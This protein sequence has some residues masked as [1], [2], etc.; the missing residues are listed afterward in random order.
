ME[1]D[2]FTVNLRIADTRYPLRIRRKEEEM[3]RKAANDIDYKLSQY[4]GYFTDRLSQPLQDK[5]YMAMTAIQAMSEKVE[6]QMRV[7]SFEKKINELTLKLDDYLKK[8]L[9]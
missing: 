4:K 9:K 5:D 2:Y 6:E 8:Y 3:F 7:D 1:N